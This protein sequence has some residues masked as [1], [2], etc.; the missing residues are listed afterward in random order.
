M[1]S[2][3]GIQVK[4]KLVV[5]GRDGSDI[6]DIVGDENEFAKLSVKE[7]E[8]AVSAIG[9]SLG[10]PPAGHIYNE[11]EERPMD[12]PTDNLIYL[13]SFP[14]RCTVLNEFTHWKQE[15]VSKI[16]FKE[17][18][19]E[20][21]LSMAA[22]L[23]RDPIL[24]LRIDGEDL[25]EFV[26]W[27]CFE[28]EVVAIF[29]RMESSGLSLQECI[30]K[31]LEQLT[32]DHG[33]PPSND[34]WVLNNIVEPVLQSLADNQ[35]YQPA[36]QE[37]FLSEFRKVVENITVRLKEHPVIV[38]HSGNTFDGSSIKSLLMNKVELEKALDD[39][40]KGLPKTV[41]QK[42]PV[43]HLRIALDAVAPSAGL[44]PYGSLS[45]MDMVVDDIFRTVNADE[46]KII[47]EAEFRNTMREILGSIMS[48]LEDSPIVFS[49][50]SV[51]HEA[52]ASSTSDTL[53]PNTSTDASSPS[54]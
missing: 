9:A 41:G 8:P 12:S 14:V 42:T 18:L 50:N 1:G 53:S 39:S 27:T 31:A 46:G 22:G 32:V 21:L 37:I 4:K 20:F 15:E 45:Q 13:V 34:S 6:R 44:I 26:N 40:W 23:D 16:E 36:S 43:E 33:M 30:I 51:V 49:S 29:S 35:Y 19:S 54:E 28:P 11:L 17:V 24:I 10:L 52:L 38:A 48:R 5:V 2:R 3:E 47:E 7:L 25:K